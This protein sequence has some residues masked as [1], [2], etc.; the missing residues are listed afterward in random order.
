[1]IAGDNTIAKARPIVLNETRCVEYRMT[2]PL[3]YGL[4]R[5]L[6]CLLWPRIINRVSKRTP[7]EYVILSSVYVKGRVIRHMC[8]DFQGRA[9]RLHESNR[10]RVALFG[11]PKAKR[12]ALQVDITS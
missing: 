5:Q 12:S 7:R 6:R 8:S 10:T 3:F 2:N 4:P 11:D 9:G 1:M